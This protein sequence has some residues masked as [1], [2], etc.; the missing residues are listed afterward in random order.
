MEAEADAEEFIGSATMGES[1]SEDA[2]NEV[3]DEEEGGPFMLLDEEARLPPESELTE[4]RELEGHEY[5]EKEQ[6]LRGARWVSRR[7]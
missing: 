3:V 7:G 1:V 2:R 5:V 6:T 4:E